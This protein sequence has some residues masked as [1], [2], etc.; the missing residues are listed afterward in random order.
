MK[1]FVSFAAA[2]ALVGSLA[3]CGSGTQSDS[4]KVAALG[5]KAVSAMHD[6]NVAKLAGLMDPSCSAEFLGSAAMAKAFGI[7]LGEFMKSAASD[8]KS[9]IDAKKV[10]ISGDKATAPNGDALAVRVNGIW[11]VDCSD[12]SNSGVNS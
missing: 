5:D 7:D 6:G 3:A 12:T 11:Y 2:V 9:D 10:T 8:I 1:K 4:Q